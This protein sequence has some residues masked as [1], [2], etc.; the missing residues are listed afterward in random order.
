MRLVVVGADGKM[1]REVMRTI[2]HMDGVELA[3]AIVKKGLSI[4]GKPAGELIGDP[5]CTITITD[6]PQAAFAKADGVIDFSAP[7]ATVA[8]AALAAEAKIV[9]IIGTTGIDAEQQQKIEDA[10]RHTTI[11][12]SGNMSLGVNLLAGLVKKA[13]AILG[14]DFDIEIAEMHHRR[15][16]DA[17]SGTALLLGEAAAQGRNVT[18]NDVSVRARDG[19]T[20]ARES[21]TI[22]FAVLRGGTVVGEHSVLFAGENEII[23]L[24]HSAQE[25]SIFARGAIKAALWSKGKDNGLYSMADVL[26]LNS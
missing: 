19:Y 17:P 18:L 10:A 22:G 7:V 4:V 12:K 16:V 5:A 25:R 3:G 21:G 26:G 2:L 11:V 6:D 24:S 20:G 23:T 8:Y 9:H 13:A 14:N 1:G 15:K